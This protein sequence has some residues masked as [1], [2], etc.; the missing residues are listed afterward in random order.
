[1]QPLRAFNFQQWID[2]HREQLRP[3]VCNQVVFE[4]AEFIVMVVGGPNS[5]KDYHFDEGEEFFYQLEG[6][7]TVKIQ[8]DGRAVAH[9]LGLEGLDGIF[10]RGALDVG[11]PIGEVQGDRLGGAGGRG[12]RVRGGARADTGR[13][14]HGREQAFERRT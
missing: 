3:P 8:E 9:A 2:E 13:Q 14:E 1:M 7:I 10:H 11:A 6:D 5:R 12:R 4:D